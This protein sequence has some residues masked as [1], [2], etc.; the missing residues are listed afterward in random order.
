VAGLATGESITNPDK[1]FEDNGI[2]SVIARVEQAD[3]KAKKIKL[4]DGQ[5]LAYDKL[6]IGVGSRPF[7][8]PLD[9]CDLEGVFTLRSLD[10]A[11]KIRTFLNKKRPRRLVFIGSGFISMEQATLLMENAPGD[12]EISIIELLGHPLPLMIDAE[13]GARLQEY[14][15]EKGLDFQMGEKVTKI[16][17][18]D[19]KVS[20]VELGSGRSIEADMV[21]MNVGA[22]PNLELAEQMGLD[23]GRFG[24]KVNQFLE[25]SDPDVLAG[26]DCIENIHFITGKPVP[27]QLRGP[28]VIQ[29]RLIAK[30]LAGYKIPFTGLLGASAVKLFNK[31]IAATGL[32]EESA[33]KENFDTVCATVDSRS[34]HAMIPGTKPWT[35]K[36]VFDKKT[37]KLIGGQIISDDIGPAKEIDAV[38]ALI[39]GEKTVSDLT[40]LMCAG[41]PDCAS[42]PSAEPITVAAEQALQKM[43]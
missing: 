1:I 3:I 30:R 19:G 20:G 21:F 5:E 36:L 7:V 33:Q 10:D 16:L 23:L 24:I 22:R 38:N 29:G 18:R 39:L 8:P 17:G 31:Y 14:L 37:E 13:F 43:K 9:G 11:E 25:T 42:E 12:Y 40:T 41:N 15:S 34:K 27:I 2:N 6:V 4:S 35:L 28:A 32:S 26:G